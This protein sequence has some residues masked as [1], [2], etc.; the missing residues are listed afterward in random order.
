MIAGRINQVGPDVAG[1]RV[2][3]FDRAEEKKAK[4]AFP[5]V[6]GTGS[7]RS[8]VFFPSDGP[9]TGN[10]RSFEPLVLF[11]REGEKDEKR[12]GFSLFGATDDGLSKLSSSKE[13]RP[14]FR[15]RTRSRKGGRN[16]L[17]T[18]RAPFR[19]DGETA[20]RVG[21][22]FSR[23]ETDGARRRP[24]RRFR[25]G[26]ARRDARRDARRKGARKKGKGARRRSKR[27]APKKRILG[28]ERTREGRETR[29][30]R[31]GKGTSPRRK[32]RKRP[33]KPD[34]ALPGH[35]DARP[36]TR[37]WHGPDGRRRS[38]REFDART[39]AKGRDARGGVRRKRKA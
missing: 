6:A 19:P 16:R 33:P 37:P 31:A 12:G 29:A 5:R 18:N 25:E 3:P 4:P 15:G 10:V 28:R 26:R 2:S 21:F 38:E 39:S 27:R 17:E 20:R 8:V 30:T 14:F 23:H 35:F 36:K 24:K 13:A 7:R 11:V 32:T 1:A 9:K 22:F 34:P